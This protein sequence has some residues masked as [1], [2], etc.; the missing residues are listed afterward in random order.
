MFFRLRDELLGGE[1]FFTLKEA[2]VL[3]QSLAPI[4]QDGLPAQRAGLQA[5]GTPARMPGG[6]GPGFVLEGLRPDRG[7]PSQ[8]NFKLSFGTVRGGQDSRDPQRY[9]FGSLIKPKR[10]S[11]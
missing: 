10:L 4:L 1:I 3:V 11:E 8:R 6:P 9:L 5:A 2:N 7:I